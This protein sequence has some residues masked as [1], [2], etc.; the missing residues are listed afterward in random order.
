MW[1]AKLGVGIPDYPALAES[2]PAS[3]FFHKKNFRNSWGSG[4]LVVALVAHVIPGSNTRCGDSLGNGEV[5]ASVLLKVIRHVVRAEGILYKQK[6]KR[7]V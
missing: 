7:G 2:S 1:K 3:L 4:Q 6:S 5:M